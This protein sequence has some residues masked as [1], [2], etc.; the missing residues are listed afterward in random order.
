MYQKRNEKWDLFPKRPIHDASTLE[1][2]VA[3]ELK[4]METANPDT[5][6]IWYDDGLAICIGVGGC[7]DCNDE[8]DGTYDATIYTR[9]MG[10]FGIPDLCNVA[11]SF[12]QKN[13]L[14]YC[15]WEDNYGGG[16]M[17][18]VLFLLHD[19]EKPESEI[20]KKLIEIRQRIKS[21][22][23]RRRDEVEART[24]VSAKSLEEAI[25]IE[26]RRIEAAVA[27]PTIR[28][29]IGGARERKK[30]GRHDQV[31][32]VYT[33]LEGA[34]KWSDVAYAADLLC[35]RHGIAWDHTDIHMERFT[36]P[37]RG[38]FTFSRRFDCDFYKN[39]GNVIDH[40]QRHNEKIEKT[41]AKDQT[42]KAYRPSIATVLGREEQR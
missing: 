5:M 16:P 31:A 36:C 11:R 26:M 27:Y 22:E 3:V 38:V 6:K 34:Y 20:S 25:D 42:V 41:K 8:Y 4:R 18:G 9:L 2:A 23:Q 32:P 40:I 24:I 1:D 35:E 33:T 19:E 13:G 30:I 14:E 10:D 39:A 29:G 21:D 28:I 15:T 17:S 37:A 12:A 7:I